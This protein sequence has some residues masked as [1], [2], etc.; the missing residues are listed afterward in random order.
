MRHTCAD[1][2]PFRAGSVTYVLF[3]WLPVSGSRS[4]SHGFMP[5]LPGRREGGPMAVRALMGMP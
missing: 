2:A 4:G 5:L 3:E 1:A